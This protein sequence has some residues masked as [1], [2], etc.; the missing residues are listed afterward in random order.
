MRE[1]FKPLG[2]GFLDKSK[3]VPEGIHIRLI[4]VSHLILP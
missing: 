4:D 2:E 1:A 3:V